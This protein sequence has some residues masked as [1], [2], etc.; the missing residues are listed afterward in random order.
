MGNATQLNLGFMW[1]EDGA[2]TDPDAADVTRANYKQGWLAEIPTMQEFNFVLNALDNNTLYLAEHG[3]FAYDA[4]IDYNEG[5]MVHSGAR[6][7]YSKT[8]SNLGNSVFNKNFWVEGWCYGDVGMSAYVNSQ[9]LLLSNIGTFSSNTL[10]EGNDITVKSALPIVAFESTNASDNWLLGNIEGEMCVVNKAGLTF[11]NNSSIAKAQSTTY[12]LFHEGHAPTQAEVSG[13]I[14]EAPSNGNSYS[15]SN[16][17][18]VV[19]ASGLSDAP[20][21]GSQ[22]AR[23]DAGWEKVADAAQAGDM[24]V[25]ALSVAAMDNRSYTP[26][27]GTEVSR[28]VAFGDLYTAIG[29]RYGDGNGA[30]TFNKPNIPPILKGSFGALGQPTRENITGEPGTTVDMARDKDSGDLYWMQAATTNR[31]H[32]SIGGTANWTEVG[33]F[34]ANVSG[35]TVQDICYD[36]FNNRLLVNCS[37]GTPS[38]IYVSYDKG[39][40]FSSHLVEVSKFINCMTVDPRNGNLWYS[41]TEGDASVKDLIKVQYSGAGSVEIAGDFLGGT[42]RT[43]IIDETNSTVWAIDDNSISYLPGGVFSGPSTAW[44]TVTA[45]PGTSATYAAL[46]EDKQIIYVCEVGATRLIYAY[47]IAG[48][49]YSTYFTGIVTDS[50]NGLEYAQDTGV[51]YIARQILGAGE[52]WQATSSAGTEDTQWYI[53]Y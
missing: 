13:T 47:D 19:A 50:W 7:F 34:E 5:A 20:S 24:V 10:W 36:E 29:D 44:I 6:T 12:R 31:L 2:I 39:L 22:Y 1:G 32:R 23:K 43:I 15:R 8:N 38:T 11:P 48:G 40:T 53:K 28:T 35:V 33:D 42:T 51:L 18:W 16:G 9:G 27:D 14:P 52:L 46:D 37:I 45:Y 41:T 3:R 21:D 4:D 30:T 17:Q 49:T 26:C 25:S